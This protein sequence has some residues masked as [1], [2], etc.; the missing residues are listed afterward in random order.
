M[1][2]HLCSYCDKDYTS[3][4]NLNRHI[5]AHHQDEEV[6]DETDREEGDEDEEEET[7]DE[8][9]DEEA[10]TPITDDFV[11]SVYKRFREEYDE[12]F[13]GFR[14]EGKSE[15]DARWSAHTQ[16]LPKYRKNFRTKVERFLVRYAQFKNEPLYKNIRKTVK[17]LEDE[18]FKP[19]ERIKSAVAKRKFLLYEQFPS[20]PED[21]SDMESD[22]E[23]DGD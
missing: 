7:E 10:S 18:N 12:L 8:S 2:S 14:D 16:L 21:G 11:K 9:S 5:E 23:N 17:A 4:F 13:Q 6:S 22:Q 1:A 19:L 3:K 20:D 15:E